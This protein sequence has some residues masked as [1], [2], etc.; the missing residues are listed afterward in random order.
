MVTH[1]T[2]TANL[3]EAVR[4]VR[5]RAWVGKGEGVFHAQSGVAVAVEEKW[6]T[7]L[8]FWRQSHRV[9]KESANNKDSIL[10]SH[11][12]EDKIG[13]TLRFFPMGRECPH[14]Y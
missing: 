5:A 2:S 11:S 10:P 12:P 8:P 7:F 1:G 9:E 14:I 13:T 3:R 4:R 6:E